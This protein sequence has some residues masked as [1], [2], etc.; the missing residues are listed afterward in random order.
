MKKTLLTMTILGSLLVAAQAQAGA[1]A[2][3]GVTSNYMFRGITQT[4]DK[5]AVQ[6]GLD[7][8]HDSGLY[9]G[10]WVSNIDF[11]PEA[12]AAE[13]S[14]AEID[15][16]GGIKRELKGGLSYDMGVIDYTYPSKKT[17]ESGAGDITE[18][19]TKLGLKG[20][21]FE[22]YY[23]V[24]AELDGVKD[25]Y[26]DY[27]LGYSGETHGIGYGVKANRMDY[28]KSSGGADYNHYQ[29]S[30]TKSFD[31]AGAVTLAVDDATGV[32]GNGEKRDPIASIS[33]KKS[34]DF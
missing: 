27:G 31:K 19:Y 1:S 10:T 5:P 20:A 14:G 18:V 9:A 23:P 11:T 15:V 25:S 17:A 2:N 8:S 13:G 22:V 3:V 30:A 4:D 6:G 7:Y 12:N 32:D 26:F 21:G 28:K 34:F 33:W 16:Y 24:A 29:I